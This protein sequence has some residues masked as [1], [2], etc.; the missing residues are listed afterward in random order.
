MKNALGRE[1]PEKIAGIGEVKAFAGAFNTPPSMNRQAPKV[2]SVRPRDSKL[3]DSCKNTS[4]RRYDIVI[5]SS[6]P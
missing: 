6:F 1:I 2:K 4:D 3:V 5:S